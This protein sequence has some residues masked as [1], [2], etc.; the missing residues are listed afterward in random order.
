MGLFRN[1]FEKLSTLY[2]YFSVHQWQFIALLLIMLFVI[3][4]LLMLLFPALIK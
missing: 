3:P 2:D 4:L 1:Y